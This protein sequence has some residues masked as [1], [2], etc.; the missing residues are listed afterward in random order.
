M[1]LILSMHTHNFNLP[2]LLELT[3]KE[4]NKFQILGN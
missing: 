2:L 4:E 3:A 1:K